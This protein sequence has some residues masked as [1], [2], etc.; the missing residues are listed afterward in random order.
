MLF[1]DGAN[2]F[3]NQVIYEVFQIR[4]CSLLSL[5]VS[6]QGRLI[7]LELV[8]SFTQLANHLVIPLFDSLEDTFVLIILILS[9][10][11][12]GLFDLILFKSSKF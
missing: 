9:Y 11:L 6:E 4:E 1:P 3:I 10:L 5:L 2:N 8:A 12:L 7:S